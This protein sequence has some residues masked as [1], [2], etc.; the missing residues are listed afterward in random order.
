VYCGAIIVQPAI[1]VKAI[2][3][4]SGMANS[5]VSAP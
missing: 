4:R 2:A 3:Y 5:D 1:N